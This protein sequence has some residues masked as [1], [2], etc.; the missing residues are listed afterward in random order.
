ME[1]FPDNFGNELAGMSFEEIFEDSPKW[2]ECV[3][4]TWTD[5][6]TGIFLRFRNYVMLR[7]K[8]IISVTEHESRC[9]AFVNNLS[10]DKIPCYMIKYHEDEYKI[11][12]L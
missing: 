10:K 11:N 2:I 12:E 7:F 5:S 9:R 8:D 1:R 6:C 4:D 3:R